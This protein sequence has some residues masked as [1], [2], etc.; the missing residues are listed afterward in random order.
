[1]EQHLCVGL[2]I[3]FVS[4][5]CHESCEGGIRLTRLI[6]VLKSVVPLHILLKTL[7]ISVLFDIC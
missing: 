6:F 4:E 5:G 7:E 3:G 1:M 2:R